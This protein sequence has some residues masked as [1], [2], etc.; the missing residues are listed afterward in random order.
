MALPVLVYYL[1]FHYKPMY[2]ALIAFK[3]LLP[4]KGVLGS[5]WVGFQHFGDSLR[6]STSGG[7]CAT[8]C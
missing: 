6:A 5:P 7:C 1:L 3:E 4:A 2:G 8:R